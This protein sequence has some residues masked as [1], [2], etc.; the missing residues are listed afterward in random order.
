MRLTAIRLTRR[1]VLAA[2]ALAATAA[3]GS[4]PAVSAAVGGLAEGR[5][6]APVVV[7]IGAESAVHWMPGARRRKVAAPSLRSATRPVAPPPAA[8]VAPASVAAPNL[9]PVHS[10]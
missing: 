2:L 6:A 10:T 5:D 4:A 1:H 9:A 3:S 7:T 8:P